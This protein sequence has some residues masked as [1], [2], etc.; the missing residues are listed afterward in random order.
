MPCRSMRNR[1]T[2]LAESRPN[3]SREQRERI[4][5][6]STSGRAV[7]RMNTGARRRLLQALQQRVRRVLGQP[8]GIVDDDDP[9]AAFERPVGGR[10]DRRPDDFDL[11]RADLGR[12]DGQNVRMRSPGDPP[13]RRARTARV[14]AVRRQAVE[15]LGHRLRR[16]P[17]ADTLGPGEQETRGQRPPGDGSGQQAERARVA[18]DPG[19]RHK[20]TVAY[21]AN[22]RFGELAN[23]GSCAVAISATCRPAD[24]ATCPKAGV[25]GPE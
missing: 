6:S 19:K 4:V 16:Q 21:R 25:G 10:G 1:A 8:I 7:T 23:R 24:P 18:E 22:V 2:S 17:L 15:R 12:F 5:G 3:R 9:A 14:P 13:A 20:T 11:R